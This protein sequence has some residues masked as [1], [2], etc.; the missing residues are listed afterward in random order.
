MDIEKLS[1]IE[2][3][4]L[5]SSIAVALEN[6]RE[7]KKAEAR[8]KLEAAAKLLGYRL[9]ELVIGEASKKAR[10]PVPVKYRHPLEPH[11]KWTGRGR[12]PK[13]VIEALSAGKSLDEL[14]V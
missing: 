11:L 2:L 12:K 9:D 8:G 14:A 7:R 13:W 3:Q 10:A 6:L 1:E 5:S 4:K